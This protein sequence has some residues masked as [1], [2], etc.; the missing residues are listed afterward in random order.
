MLGVQL[1]DTLHSDDKSLVDDVQRLVGLQCLGGGGSDV[2]EFHVQD[3]L[4]DLLEDGVCRQ[5]LLCD[6]LGGCL[7]LGLDVVTP[8]DRSEIYTFVVNHLFS[9]F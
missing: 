9:S 8:E 4:S 6:C 7:V 1:C 2:L 3:G 5:H